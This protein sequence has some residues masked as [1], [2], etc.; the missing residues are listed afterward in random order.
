MGKVL[1]QILNAVSIRNQWRLIKTV[2]S[3]RNEVELTNTITINDVTRKDVTNFFVFSVFDPAFILASAPA[4]VISCKPYVAYVTIEG[5]PKRSAITT[6]ALPRLKYV[7]VSEFVAKMLKEVGLNVVA[8]VHHAI[9]VDDSIKA[10]GL[11]GNVEAKLRGQFGD[12]VLF[13]FV[14]RNDPRK[15][16][17]KMVQANTI[18]KNRGVDGYRIIVVSEP[19]I[20]NAINDDRFVFAND[21]G[22][23]THVQLLSIMRA[24]DYVLF[25]TKCEGFGLP[26]LESMSVGTPCVHTWC[27]P[28]TEFSSDEFN[29]VYEYDG[30]K[31]VD[32]RL[33]QRFVMHDYDPEYLADSMEDAIDV[34]RNRRDEYEDY[35]IKAIKH[36]INW[37]YRLLYTTLA[38]IGDV[39]VDDKALRD[40]Y[41]SSVERLKSIFG[42]VF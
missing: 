21:F 23:L 12:D 39:D 15:G 16:V 22:S 31:V 1:A 33:G 7:A 28:L 37:D 2:F 25:P 4:L 35:R 41:E 10:I 30:V 8:H 27:P 6:S 40:S 34:R 9:N 36:S 18:L 14:A 19:S 24:V 38:R 11:A 29:F 5:L 13:L 32:T 20:K 42:E 26:V 17:E 3:T